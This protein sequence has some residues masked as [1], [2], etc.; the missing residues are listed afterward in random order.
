MKRSSAISQRSPNGKQGKRCR[1][2]EP[3]ER[4]SKPRTRR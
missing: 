1:R 4:Q 3:R 2:R